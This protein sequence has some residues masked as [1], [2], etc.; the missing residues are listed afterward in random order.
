MKRILLKVI[1][2]IFARLHFFSNG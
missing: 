1:K 2:L